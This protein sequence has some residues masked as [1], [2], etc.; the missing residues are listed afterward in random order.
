MKIKSLVFNVAVAAGAFAAG[1]ASAA[2][3]ALQNQNGAG[4]GNAFA[5]AAAAAEDASTVYFN[6]AG[7]LLL[8]KGHNIT[9]AVT[10]LERSVEF[11]DRG[12]A[13]LGPFALGSDGG[14]G[15][16]CGDRRDGRNGIDVVCWLCGT[17]KVVTCRNL[18][19][20]R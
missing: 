8:P 10:F 17:K 15:S 16:G 3:F 5:G 1:S 4:T 18:R 7:M 13:R 12:T 2:G 20:R 19:L 9:G 6:P 11:S 14:D